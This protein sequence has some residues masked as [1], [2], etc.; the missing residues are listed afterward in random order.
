[1]TKSEIEFKG[2]KDDISYIK[3]CI[4]GNGEPGLIKETKANTNFRIKIKA[5]LDMIKALA[6]SGLVIAIINAVI[7]IFGG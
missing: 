4:A 7:Q 5:Q 3:K 1:M 2:I 6:G